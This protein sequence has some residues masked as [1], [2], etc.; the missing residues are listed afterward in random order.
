VIVVGGGAMTIVVVVVVVVVVVALTEKKVFAIRGKRESGLIR[1]NKRNGQ[2]TREKNRSNEK[3]PTRIRIAHKYVTQHHQEE[4]EEQAKRRRATAN[5]ESTEEGK[6]KK[7][8][9]TLQTNSIRH[10]C[11]ECQ[12]HW[13][14]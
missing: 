13:G 3:K 2:V 11:E 12:E 6:R 4:E 10:R 8:L 5:K 7:R 1:V 14:A 9:A